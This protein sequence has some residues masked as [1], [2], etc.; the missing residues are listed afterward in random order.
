TGAERI[1]VEVRGPQREVSRALRALPQVLRVDVTRSDDS[2]VGLFVESK[3]GAD[4]RELLASTIVG[5]GW[6]LRELK[7]AGLSLEEIFVKVVTKEEPL[8][9]REEVPA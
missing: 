1:H 5:R 7:S 8:E 2:Q 3:L 9:A 6:G 4:I